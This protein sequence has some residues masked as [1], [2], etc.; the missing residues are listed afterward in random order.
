MPYRI[1][2]SLIASLT[3]Y[4]TGPTELIAKYFKNTYQNKFL[5]KILKNQDSKIFP[6]PI[7]PPKEEELIKLDLIKTDPKECLN[8]LFIGSLMS[9]YDFETIK[10]VLKFLIKRK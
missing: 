6:S 9:V 3:D 5:S 8:I 7:V 4:I 10:K 1:Y 2:S